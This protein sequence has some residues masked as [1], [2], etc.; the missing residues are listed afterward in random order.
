MSTSEEEKAEIL[1]RRLE[2]C[3]SCLAC[4]YLYF[5]DTGYS[6]YTVTDT[7][8]ACL[9]DNNPNL[10]ADKPYDWDMRQLEDNWP[11]TNMSLCEKAHLVPDTFQRV[12]LDVDGEKRITDF[13]LPN[14]LLLAY[15]EAG[16]R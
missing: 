12:H 4:A 6:N 11:K 15:Y 9:K 1:I 8:V 7:T 16:F 14:D 2:G 10:P 13:E 3:A 5:K